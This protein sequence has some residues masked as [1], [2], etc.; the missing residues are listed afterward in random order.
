MYINI[1]MTWQLIPRLFC[2][3]CIQH[4]LSFSYSLQPPRSH[5]SDTILSNLNAATNDNG[6]V[7]KGGDKDD[8]ALPEIPILPT[9]RN[10]EE[11][12]TKF[13]PPVFTNMTKEEANFIKSTLMT[14]F[15]FQSLSDKTL[16]KLVLAFEKIEYKKGTVIITQGDKNIDYFYVID[17]GEC[18]VT[19]DG[20]TLPYPYGTLSEGNMFGDLAMLY[21]VPRKATVSAKSDTITLFRVDRKTFRYF[22]DRQQ[23]QEI[24]DVKEELKDIDSAIDKIAGVNSRYSGDI[25]KQYKPKRSWLWRRWTGT[26]LQRQYKVAL[27]QMIITASIGILVRRSSTVKW[28][29][30]SVP[31]QSNL[32]I[33]RM[34]AFSKHWH[35][36]QGITTFILTFF[37]SQAYSHWREMYSAARKIQGRLNDVNFLLTSIATR[38]E[39]G[40]YT[41]EAEKVLDN[42]SSYTRLFHAFVWSKFATKNFGKLSTSRGQSRMLSRG[43]MTQAE[44]NALRAINQTAGAPNACL[45]WIAIRALKG[46]KDGGL[47]HDESIIHVLFSKI[48][49]LRGT[50]AGIG[51]IIAGRMPLAYTHIVQILVDIF[52]ATAPIA[53]YAELGIWAPLSVGILTLFYSGLLDLAKIFLDPLDNDDFCDESINMDIGVLI[54]EGNAG[55]TRWKSAAQILPF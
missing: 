42:V 32:I 45:Q 38:D 2:I 17:K 36:L 31:D 50:Y 22:L 46:T 12:T 54:R 11:T 15:M 26:I 4:G 16:D 20:K 44:F 27:L 1:I 37:L 47:N 53:L 30:G 34:I 7:I 6:I 24:D 29:I 3:L 52:L 14:N 10:D 18:D 39:N 9:L 19:V 51:D 35:Y 40:D 55:S 43:L 49:E 5:I 33:S 41:P 21:N 23:P 48:S 13:I 8:D 28:P 25:I